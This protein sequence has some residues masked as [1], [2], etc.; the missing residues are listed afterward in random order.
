MSG[1]NRIVRLGIGPSTCK[2][3]GGA[4]SGRFWVQKH[5]V[6]RVADTAAGLTDDSSGLE[7]LSYRPKDNQIVRQPLCSTTGS[8]AVCG[9]SSLI[10]VVAICCKLFQ[11]RVDYRNCCTRF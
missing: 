1:V 6:R 11:V 5:S 7:S 2:G 10:V 9:P 8:L 4:S 3:S